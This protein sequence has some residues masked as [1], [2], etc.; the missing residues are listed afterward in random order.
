MDATTLAPPP[1]VA[2]STPFVFVTHIYGRGRQ[3]DNVRRQLWSLCARVSIWEYR[4]GG[5][6]KG[7]GG[8]MDVRASDSRLL[9]ICKVFIRRRPPAR[10]HL[11]IDIVSTINS[12][13]DA[14]VRSRCDGHTVSWSVGG[15]GVG[16]GARKRRAKCS[17]TVDPPIDVCD[18]TFWY[19]M[20]LVWIQILGQV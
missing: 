10:S 14:L 7:G 18:T 5:E 1:L 20:V 12:F 6:E 17:P 13:F 2:R 3:R 9:F 8:M 4:W 16:T 11:K 15:M 19:A